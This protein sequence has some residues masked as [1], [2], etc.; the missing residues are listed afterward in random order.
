[1]LSVVPAR[2]IS[3]PQ[4]V[5]RADQAGFPV[6]FY[7]E[8]LSRVGDPVAT[9]TD[10]SAPSG[11][12]RQVTALFADMVGFTAISERVGEEGTFALIQPIYELMA[13]AVREQGG[14]VTDFL[15]DGIMAL[16][17]ASDA[18][19]DAALRACRAGLLIHERLAAAAPA[20]EDKHGVRPHMRIG[21]NSG[22]VVVTQIRGA[23]GRMAALGDT[24]NL[25]SRL[26]ALAEPGT[27]N[28]SEATHRLVHGLV[29]TTF[30]GTHAIKGK[31]EPQKVYRLNALLLGATR[32]EVAVGRGLSPYVGRDRELGVLQRTLGDAREELRVIDIV[33]EPGMGK[34]RLLHEFRQRIGEE[35]AFILTG[36]CSPDGRQTPFLPFIEVV[37]G[38]FQVKSREGEND[39]VR[40]LK[41][42]LA[43]LGLNS[44]E[45]LGLLLNMFGL[46]PPEGALTGLD[47]VLI[48]LRTRDLLQIMLEARCRLSPVVLLIEDLHWIDSASQEVLGGMVR[49]DT[50][51]RLMILHTRRPEYAPTWLDRPI[52][53][54][55]GLEPLSASDI[56]LLI[57]ARLEV[58]VL[59]E[60]LARLVMERSEG[61]P[62]FAEEI[63]SFLTERGVLR[64]G[65]RKVEFDHDAVATALPV[66]V[67][68]LLTARVDRLALQ[69]RPLL[70]AA[71]VIGRRFDSRL[72]AAVDGGSDVES[73]L[74]AMQALDLVRPDGKFGDYSFKHALVRDA[75][76]QSLLTGPRMALHLKIAEE[77]E[78]GHKNHLVEV[79]ESLAHHYHRTDRGDK[80]FSY[81][82]LAG[83]KS[84]GLYSLEEAEKYLAAAIALVETN[85]ECASDQQVAD[86]LVDYTFLSNLSMRFGAATKIVERFKFRLEQLATNPSCV[87]VQHHYVFALSSTAR[88]REAASAQADLST[89]ATAL[90][91]AKAIAYALASAVQ[92]SPL[93]GLHSADTF[94]VLSNEA[95]AM[96][97][98]LNDPYLQFLVRHAVVQK[99]FFSGRITHAT[100]AAE[101]LVE[102]G[103]RM[104]DPRSL[105]YG[106]AL[107]A[108]VALGNEDYRA[109]LNFG[110][111]GIGVARTPYDRE[112]SNQAR[113]DAL[114]MLKR[115]EGIPMLRD[116]IERCSSNGWNT[117][118]DVVEGVW[119]V[120]LI[121]Q[122]QIRK[123]IQRMEQTI[124]RCDREGFS[125]LADVYRIFL[126]RV[127]L[128]ILTREEKLPLFAL[129]RNAPTLIATI[130]TA[131]RRICALAEKAR[132]NPQFDP[133]GMH[134][135]R[136]EA[137][138]GL[139]YKFNNK[140]ALALQH[141]TEAK[142]IASQFGTTP[143]LAK[144]E[145]ALAK[146]A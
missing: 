16:F 31:A 123:G 10:P 64:A 86:L 77:I 57:Q 37:R 72:L 48:G 139:L 21:I 45:S 63:V 22:P 133:N 130:F 66:S 103:R 36:S 62:L 44:A 11:E 120:A 108:N 7:S 1:V 65:E 46:N 85:P 23:N 112:F 43:A 53:T 114:V 121:I 99:E 102:V 97:S 127:Y 26:Q 70:Q 94:D 33:A 135:A 27:V 4:K 117:S 17:G 25:A 80:A 42:G 124:L 69:A 28:L 19:E 125:V 32:F 95:L 140:R 40:K 74:A 76:Y 9:P 145:E 138:L 68:S 58:E 52:V 6:S 84:L 111:M 18:P 15:G 81:L 122:G 75:L 143:T 54:G 29:E 12:R 35:Q 101:E 38:A 119:G 92:L 73:R 96:A 136:I 128:E 24:V 115:P 134:V 2:A 104:N 56:R 118:L 100:K 131:Q 50:K 30:A 3:P 71:A 110:D 61:N 91:D 89:A 144:I 105:G 67:Q 13:G 88:F 109:A 126:C 51:L 129:L 14:S 60:A 79:A 41:M 106:L 90:G 8:G 78:R 113:I 83:A 141:L 137:I 55:L 87:F 116:Y 5:E 142:R 146:L 107:M 47:G 34:S 93:I 132:Q 49:G 59:P 39:V 98:S 20:I 82:A